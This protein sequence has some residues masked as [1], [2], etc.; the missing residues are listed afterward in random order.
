MSR[1]N[2]VEFKS[3]LSFYPTL[4]ETACWFSCSPDTIE[5]KSL[6]Y[7]NL[8]FKE[9]RDRFCGKTRLLLK[10]KAISKALEED[11]EKMLLY[12]LRTMTDLDDRQITSKNV[13]AQNVIRL[14]YSEKEL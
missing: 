8:T 12:C 5:R 6:E 14:S 9:A 11:N 7:W 13:E 2:E 1:I 10:R 4:E 3:V